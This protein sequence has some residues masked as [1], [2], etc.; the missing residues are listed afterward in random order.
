MIPLFYDSNFSTDSCRVLNIKSNSGELNSQTRD[1]RSE[2]ASWKKPSKLW[3]LFCLKGMTSP[4]SS[5]VTHVLVIILSSTRS[6]EILHH[7]QLAFV[8]LL[9]TYKAYFRG[10]R[11]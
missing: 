5:A 11:Y 9:L 3:S 4:T 6:K 1:R 8:Q 10:C 2:T 7:P